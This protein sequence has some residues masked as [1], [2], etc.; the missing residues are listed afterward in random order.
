MSFLISTAYAAPSAPAQGSV[1]MQFLM[2]AVMIAVFYFLLIRP[3]NRRMKEHRML[4]ESLG[5]GSEVIFAG[6]LMGR[7][8]KIDGDYAVVELNPGNQIKV[9][10]ASV[11]SVLP[12]GTLNQL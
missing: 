9:Q 11:T 6:G 10:R 12:D 2:I 1:M 8:I 3:Q 5:V 7:I 4:I